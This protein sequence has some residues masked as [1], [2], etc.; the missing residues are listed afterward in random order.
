MYDRGYNDVLQQLGIEKTAVN[1]GA[2]LRGAGHAGP[3]AKNVSRTVSGKLKNFGRNVWRSLIG[4][5]SA[6]AK[7]LRAGKAFD[8]GGLIA[9]GFAAPG[10]LNKSLLYGLPAASAMHTLMSD[11]PNR[12]QTLGGLA[13]SIALGSAAFGPVGMLGSIPA[14][15][16][17]DIIGRRLV[18]GAKRIMGFG[19]RPSPQYTSFQQP[20]RQQTAVPYRV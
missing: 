13:G 15:Y 19:N 17:G 20:N 7:E 8:R 4:Q 6:F 1:W 14:S 12:A 5:P 10:L 18:G 9:Q 16:A 11:D 3:T 2:V